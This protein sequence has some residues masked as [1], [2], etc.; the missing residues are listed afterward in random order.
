MY[1]PIFEAKWRE[2]GEVADSGTTQV[3][4]FN[5]WAERRYGE[6]SRGAADAIE[7][8]LTKITR[9]LEGKRHGNP[10][11]NECEQASRAG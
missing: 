10:T 3:V 6:G 1:H 7:F 11:E 8:S 4:A 9:K 2:I 5:R